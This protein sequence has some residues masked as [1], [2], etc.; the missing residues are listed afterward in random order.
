MITLEKSF[1]LDL[2]RH[3]GIT[4]ARSAQV[5]SPEAAVAFAS[6]RA[7]ALYRLETDDMRLSEATT[8]G[9]LEGTDHIRHAFRRLAESAPDGAKF[10]AQEAHNNAVH[11]S[12][13]CGTDKHLGKAISLRSGAHTAMRMCP[14]SEF[15]AVAML[16]ELRSKQSPAG[17]EKAAHMLE[18]LL[19]K[20]AKLYLE[21][22]A[23]SVLVEPIDVHDNRYVVGDALILCQRKPTLHARL[24]G[25]AHDRSAFGMKGQK[26]IRSRF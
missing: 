6:G 2:F 8:S 19:T 10:F 12:V 25:D 5:D 18:H 24:T 26:Q 1:T 23:E 9:T 17:S 11:L 14:L 7:I 4:V 15:E 3:Y 21:T 22:D 16:A 13:F 20:I